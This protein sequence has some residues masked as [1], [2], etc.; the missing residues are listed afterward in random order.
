MFTLNPIKISS[1]LF[2]GHK[3]SLA[4]ASLKNHDDL[5]KHQALQAVDLLIDYKTN[6]HDF[7]DEIVSFWPLPQKI[8][9][10]YHIH[11]ADELN[12]WLENM[13]NH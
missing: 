13:I 12:D 6:V 7:T 3:S 1:H 5:G 10:R 8:M 11:S 9:D 4:S 2:S